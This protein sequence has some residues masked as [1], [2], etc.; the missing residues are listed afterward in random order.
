MNSSICIPLL[1]SHGI[2]VPWP[3]PWAPVQSVCD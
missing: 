2:T 1:H 3:G